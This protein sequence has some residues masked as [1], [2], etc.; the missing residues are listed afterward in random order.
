MVVK[1]A[2]LQQQHLE[3]ELLVQMHLDTLQA[4]AVA[5]AVRMQML[6]LVFTEQCLA[7]VVMALVAT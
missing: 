6:A 5:V 7:L 1:V 2:R 4:E 3:A